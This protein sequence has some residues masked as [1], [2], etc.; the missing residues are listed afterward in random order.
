MG[1][2][3]A[4]AE[5]G[6]TGPSPA[7]PRSGDEGYV[8]GQPPR[9]HD[10]DPLR[11]RES[12]DEPPERVVRGR[13]LRPGEWEPTPDL[14]PDRPEKKDQD[15]RADRKGGRHGKSPVGRR[16]EYWGLRDATRGAVGITRPI[17]VE[18]YADR[19]VVI[20][21]RGPA[22]NRV[23]P[24]GK[25]TESSIDTFISAIWGQMEAWGMAGRGMYWR[26]V[27]QVS[28]APDAR[29]RFAELATLLEGSGLAVERK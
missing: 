18:C 7:G 13:A 11:R 12:A 9:E 14:P 29:Q 21:D 27:L 1:S 26:P 2:S 22:N 19:L 23:V 6:G 28:V 5:G 10:P 4:G 8:A 24:L 20:S 15:D 3:A 25:S 17:R 16:G